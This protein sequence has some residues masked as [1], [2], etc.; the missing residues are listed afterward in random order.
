MLNLLDVASLMIIC[1]S[2]SLITFFTLKSVLS[3]I[4]LVIPD[5]Y[6]LILYVG[7]FYHDNPSVSGN[8]QKVGFSFMVNLTTLCPLVGEFRLLVISLASIIF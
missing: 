8:M 7:L 6:L 5:S 2:L 3:N 1:F 4:S